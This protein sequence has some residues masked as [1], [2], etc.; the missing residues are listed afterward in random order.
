MLNNETIKSAFLSF[1]I[2]LLLTL[3]VSAAPGAEDFTLPGLDG[4]TYSLRQFRG[5][6]VVINFW[7]SWCKECLQEM[8]E[9]QAL[10]EEYRDDGLVVLGISVDRSKNKAQEV[11][12]KLGITYPVLHDENGEVF[13]EKYTV[14][15]LPSTFIVDKQGR[16]VVRLIGRQDLLSERF[17]DMIERLVK[18]GNQ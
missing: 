18:G 16:L 5:R 1:S 6:V 4:K 14:V 10:Y 12:K 8:P 11:V 2:L 7:A 9:L 13:V 3:P 17:R 15:G